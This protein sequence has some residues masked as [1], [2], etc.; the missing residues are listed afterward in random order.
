MFTPHW[1]HVD[2]VL[3]LDVEDR[4]RVSFDGPSA[5]AGHIE[6]VAVTGQPGGGVT[7]DVPVGRL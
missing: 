1:P 5:Q 3:S 6:F 7:R 4:V 2:T